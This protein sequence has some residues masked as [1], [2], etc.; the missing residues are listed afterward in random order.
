[1]PGS[2]SKRWSARG[3]GCEPGAGKGPAPQGDG[4]LALGDPAGL[5]LA[6]GAEQAEAG[7]VTHEAGQHLDV[8]VA[9]NANHRN[10]LVREPPHPAFQLPV[11]LEEVLVPDRRR[12]R[13]AA[14][15]PPPRRARPPRCGATL[16]RDRA[17]AGTGRTAAA[18][19]CGRGGCRRPRGSSSR[20]FPPPPRLDVDNAI[21]GDFDH[22]VREGG[23]TAASVFQRFIEAP[24]TVAIQW[25]PVHQGNDEEWR[26][27]YCTSFLRKR[28]STNLIPAM[29]VDGI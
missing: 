27:A 21:H 24:E 28:E 25:I 10:A 19:A 22:A 8:V 7:N 18:K 1:M 29:V 9:G 23:F 20:R 17:P 12:P 16:R 4:L 6:P 13:R 26:Y 5:P 3:A 11:R 15:P 2:R 14:P